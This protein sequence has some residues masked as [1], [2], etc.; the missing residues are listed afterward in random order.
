LLGE[1]PEMKKCPFGSHGK[2]IVC[3]ILRK[4]KS[5]AETGLQKKRKHE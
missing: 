3:A 5:P 2:T 4:G 1:K